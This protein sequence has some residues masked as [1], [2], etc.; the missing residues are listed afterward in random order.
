ME[1]DDSNFLST[2]DIEAGEGDKP[3]P[4]P[5]FGRGKWKFSERE[6]ATG[7]IITTEFDGERI[8][9]HRKFDQAKYRAHMRDVRGNYVDSNGFSKN[10]DLRHIAEVPLHIWMGWERKYGHS[11]IRQDKKLLKRLIYEYGLAVVNGKF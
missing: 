11:T 7:D 10:R 2:R 6:E 3:L 1:L 5:L 8:G 9:Q 4:H